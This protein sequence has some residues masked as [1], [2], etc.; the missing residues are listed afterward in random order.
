MLLILAE[1]D[2]A[3]YFTIATGDVTTTDGQSESDGPAN[4][5]KVDNKMRQWAEIQALS[6]K[7][8]VTEFLE[9]A[10]EKKTELKITLEVCVCVCVCIWYVKLYSY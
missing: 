1:F 2:L 4:I 9:L 5:S 10:G 7:I 6:R 3:V 8:T